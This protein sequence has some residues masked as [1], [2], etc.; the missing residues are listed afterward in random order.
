MEKQ[1]LG[2]IETLGLVPAV[3]AA[4]TGSKAANVTLLG[5]GNVDAGLITVKFLGDVAAVKAAVTAAAA[6]A[7]RVGK[8]VSVHVIPRPDRQLNIG[9]PQAPPPPEDRGPGDAPPPP[10]EEK[11]A[12]EAPPQ[13]P[14]STV[15]S[16][17]APPSA[18]EEKEAEEVPPEAP[19]STVES[20][21]P[22]P[23]TTGEEKEKK[24]KGRKS[25]GGRKRG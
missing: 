25:Q 14:P 23:A 11:E 20:T 3:E 5:Y 24:A 16:E 12:E 10:P 22:P 17:A 8:V 18:P 6:A 1:S 9:P 13:A 15:E 2:L 7:K 19:P 21:G 4:D